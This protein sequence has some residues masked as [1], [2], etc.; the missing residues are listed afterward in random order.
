MTIRFTFFM[1]YA[2]WNRWPG[3][4]RIMTAIIM[5]TAHLRAIFL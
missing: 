3:I 5:N 4:R 1:A 2:V